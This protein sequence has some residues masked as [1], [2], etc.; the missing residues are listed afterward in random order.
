MS[1]RLGQ[2]AKN[3]RSELGRSQEALVRTGHVKL[4]TL[5]AIEQGQDRAYQG[6]TLAGL[7]RAQAILDAEKLGQAGLVSGSPDRDWI[8]AQLHG[9]SQAVVEAVT[10]ALSELAR[11]EP[12]FDEMVALARRLERG[13]LAAVLRLMRSL[14]G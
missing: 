2:A 13:D 12:P 7:D 3:R 4:A 8:T 6:P 14:A 1:K 9:Q 10:A 11:L 5:R